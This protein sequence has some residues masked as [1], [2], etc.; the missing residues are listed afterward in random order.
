V[1]FIDI[2]IFFD[3]IYL[4]ILV[5]VRMAGIILFNPIFQRQNV[6]AKVKVALILGSTLI[7]APVVK[8]DENFD[9][10]AIDLLLCIG[11]ELF[12]SFI[13]SFVFY[14]FYYMLAVAG[15]LLD[16]QFGFSMAKVMDPGT[17]IQTAVTGNII[18]MLFILYFF[19]TDSHLVLIKMV[20][21]TYGVIPVGVPYIDFEATAKFV[22]E[23]FVSSFSLV[24]RLT[25]P[26]I[27]AEFILE[28][29]MG[30]LMKL[31][32]QIHIFVINLQSKILIAMLLLLVLAY[33]M[34]VF[35]DNYIIIMFENIRKSIF[36]VSGG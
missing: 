23:I 7:I 27:I 3:N 18:N 1:I 6:I 22:F 8:L 11:K 9:P 24:I 29:C 21:Y 17:N 19:I 14:L 31:I 16:T 10:T 33:P 28:V 25:F 26:Y 34:T 20:A 13:F 36:V 5:F 35:I 32:P 2:S 30:I 12:I 15:D 4:Y